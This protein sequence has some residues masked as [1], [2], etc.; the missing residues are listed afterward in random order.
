M[1]FFCF[2]TN[3]QNFSDIP[4]IWHGGSIS[5]YYSTIMIYPQQKIGVFVSTTNE[6]D[7]AIDYS[8][9]FAFWLVDYTLGNKK[10][11]RFSTSYVYSLLRPS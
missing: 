8:K 5:G 3:F 4:Y 1:K 2:K 7:M 11:S 10:V 6:Q 9:M